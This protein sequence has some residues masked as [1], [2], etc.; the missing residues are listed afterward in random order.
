MPSP[1]KVTV[2]GVLMENQRWSCGFA[3]TVDGP[4]ATPT[5]AQMTAFANQMYTDWLSA[6]WNT[7]A[8]GAFAIKGLVGNIGNVDQ[9]RAYWRDPA[10]GRAQV[11]GA[12]TGASQAGTNQRL[13]PPQNAMVVS[14]LTDLAGRHNRGRIYLPW[15]QSTLNGR[16]GGGIASG[17]ATSIAN[18]ISLARTRQVAGY[19]LFPVVDSSTVPQPQITAVRSDNVVDTQRRRRD[20]VTATETATVTLVVG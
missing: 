13:V 15:A 17:V 19:T 3:F 1:I 11:V 10:T 16:I 12:S 2:G 9:V 14:L 5:G 8:S 7:T 20:K 4:T 6:A 18:F